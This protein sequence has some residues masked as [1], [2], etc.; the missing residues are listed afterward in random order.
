MA[1]D[2]LL[3]PDHLERCLQPLESQPQLEIVYT[4]PLWVTLEGY[5]IPLSYS[6]YDWVT[7]ERFMSR[8]SNG[9]PS[10]C[11]VHR[12]SCFEKYGY[13]NQ[14]LPSCADWDMWARIIEGGGRRNFAF[15]PEPTSLHFRA[16]WRT[17]ANAGPPELMIWRRFYKRTPGLPDILKQAVSEGTVQQKAFW[18]RISPN[19]ALWTGQVRWA[20]THALDLRV[21]EA[22]RQSEP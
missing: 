16:N 2:D 20:V 1:H 10:A 13:W 17:D 11:V 15:L 4:R 18:E 22:D 7:F 9:I 12:R 21:A 3:L 6:L 19:P 5:I 8:S 14:E